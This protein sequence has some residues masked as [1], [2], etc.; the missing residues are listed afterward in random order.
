[1]NVNNVLVNNQYNQVGKNALS[2]GASANGSEQ[3]NTQLQEMVDEYKDTVVLGNNESDFERKYRETLELLQ[4]FSKQF[5]AD[6]MAKDRTFI[7]LLGPQPGDDIAP[8]TVLLPGW[9][10]NVYVPRPPELD[11]PPT[12]MYDP[13][14]MKQ[15]YDACINYINDWARAMDANQAKLGAAMKSFSFFVAE[16]P[17]LPRGT[18][19]RIDDMSPE[20]LMSYGFFKQQV[21]PEANPK[22]D[23]VADSE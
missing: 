10:E 8:F 11:N 12:G 21:D 14:A 9:S 16:M 13:V 4:A 1:M 20:E 6:S 17:E 23:S 18:A 3:E 22:V 19:K 2:T 7:P 5:Y 15:H